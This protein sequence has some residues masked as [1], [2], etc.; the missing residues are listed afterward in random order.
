MRAVQGGT[1][2]QDSVKEQEEEDA[3]QDAGPFGN[4]LHNGC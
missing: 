3:K 4:R 2:A 1:G